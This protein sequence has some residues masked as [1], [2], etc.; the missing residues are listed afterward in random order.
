MT[1][2]EGTLVYVCGLTGKLFDDLDTVATLVGK[3]DPNSL[4]HNDPKIQ[5]YICAAKKKVERAHDLI[6]K[7][8][9]SRLEDKK[10]DK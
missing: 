8:V 7:M 6:W 3:G 1:R 5:K 10:E 2:Q 4:T 9:E